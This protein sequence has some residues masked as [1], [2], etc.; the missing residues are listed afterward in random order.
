MYENQYENGFV[1]MRLN[2]LIMKIIDEQINTVNYVNKKYKEL[3]KKYDDLTARNLI[4]QVLVEEIYNTMKE[5]KTSNEK[6]YRKKIEKI[7]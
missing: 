5:N 1:N 2:T 6:K 7:K 4:G 3:L